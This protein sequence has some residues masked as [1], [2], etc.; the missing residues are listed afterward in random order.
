M[1]VGNYY[2]VV[3]IITQQQQLSTINLIVS[4]NKLQASEGGRVSF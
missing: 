2:T 4:F 1:I 3:A